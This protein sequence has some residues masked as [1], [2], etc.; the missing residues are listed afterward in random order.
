MIQVLKRDC[1]VEAFRLERLRLCLL[2]AMHGRC[3]HFGEAHQLA[4][5]V[6]IYLRRARCRVV[7]SRAILEMALKVLR[8]TGH[9]AAAEALEAHH[10]R[11]RAAR[12]R[13]VVAH[14]SGRQCAWDRSWVAEQLQ[15]RWDLPRAVARTLSGDIERDLLDEGGSIARQTVLDLVD[16]RVE[17]YGLAPWCLMASAPSL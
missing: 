10:R 6:G 2:K 17:N 16:E 9:H 14:E 7:T 8:Q 13:L 3:G 5:A 12:G 15:H 4:R 1:S 11:R